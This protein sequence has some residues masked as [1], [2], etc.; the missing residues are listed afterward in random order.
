MAGRQTQT[1]TAA[2]QG[3]AWARRHFSRE[4][5]STNRTNLRRDDGPVHVYKRKHGNR[6]T[7]PLNGNPQQLKLSTNK[8]RYAQFN[9]SVYGWQTDN[10]GGGPSAS[11]TLQ[12]HEHIRVHN[13]T[14]SIL[15]YVITKHYTDVT[16]FRFHVP[17]TTI[18]DR[19]SCCAFSL[20]SFC[21]S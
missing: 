18:L 5:S 12:H 6:I 16:C 8:Q 11:T 21:R 1:A 2:S 7:T 14:L 17:I 15:F 13:G 9:C 10:T 19:C 20:S 4:S 3:W